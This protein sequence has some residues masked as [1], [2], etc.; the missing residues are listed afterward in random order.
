MKTAIIAIALT[1]TISGC[2]SYNTDLVSNTGQHYI[3]AAS[4]FGWLGT[5][6]AMHTHSE[7]LAV[8]SRAG[9]KVVGEI[10]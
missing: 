7:C 10:K 9:Y 2:V 6:I 8:A 1:C 4:G 5:P 3:C